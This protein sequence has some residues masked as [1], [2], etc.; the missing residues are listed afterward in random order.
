MEQ[1]HR[2]LTKRQ[3]QDVKCPRCWAKPGDPCHEP[4]GPR[5]N[6]HAERVKYAVR[7]NRSP[8]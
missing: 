7:I 8:D 1:R 4:H 5:A 3:I 2:W 6:A